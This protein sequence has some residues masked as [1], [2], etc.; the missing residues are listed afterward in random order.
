MPVPPILKFHKL[1]PNVDLP[2]FA[3]A[4]SACFDLAYFPHGTKV[5]GFSVT[6]GPFEREVNADGGIGIMQGERLLLP[7][8]LIADIPSGYSI[9]V[10]PRSG[11]SV[12]LGLTLANAEGII[13][14]DYVE[15]IFLTAHNTSQNRIL[16]SKG[17]RIAQGELVQNERYFIQE[18]E[19][20]PEQKTSRQGGFG[21]TGV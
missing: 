18:I 12:K 9:R 14:S 21:S 7:T 11:T 5:K 15:E 19:K 16:I 13:D 20:R 3:T 1:H 17:D 8:G 4:G 6:N 2:K 10:H